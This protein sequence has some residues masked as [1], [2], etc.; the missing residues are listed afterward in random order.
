[1]SNYKNKNGDCLAPAVY[2]S[3]SGFALGNWIGV[4]RQNKIN[5]PA[6]RF[7]RLEQV[8]FV[9]D[10]RDHK[11]ERN[12]QELCAYQNEKGD[13]LPVDSYKTTSGLMLGRWVTVQRE[14]KDRMTA[15][16]VERL[17]EIGFVWDRGD[18]HDQQW[19]KGFKELLAYKDKTGDCLVVQTYRLPSGFTLGIWVSRQRRTKH[20]LSTER[21]KRLDQIGFIWDNT[22]IGILKWEESFHLLCIYK[23]ENGDCL[24]QNRYKTSSGY[25]LGSWVSVQRKQKDD[26]GKERIERLNHIG[27]IWNT[28]EHIWEKAFLDLTVYKDE[29]TDCLVPRHYKTPSGYGLGFWVGQ[30]R[31][32]KDKLTSDQIERLDQID[33]YWGKPRGSLDDLWNKGVYELTLYKDEKG[34]CLV[35]IRHKSES[36]YALG[37]WV[38][39]QRRNKDKIR[40]DR[41]KRLDQIGFV[42]K[43]K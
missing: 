5:L 21:I 6:D 4:Q 29:N 11:W 26:L 42:W 31:K 41:L 38:A 24:V 12:F 7:E 36:D 16:R 30:Q 28:S 10:N 35:P 34:D 22:G 25:G 27:F 18:V 15:E 43:I 3:P 13:C 8:G 1:L 17:N 23:E 2:K 19:E 39:A 9:W 33:F 32:E 20:T 14:W 40:V 37:A